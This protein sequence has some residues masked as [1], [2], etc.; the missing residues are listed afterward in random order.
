LLGAAHAVQHV[1]HFLA[2]RGRRSRLAV[3]AGEHGQICQRDGEFFQPGFQLQDCRQH[4]FASRGFQHQRMRQVVD[5]FRGAGEV[6]EFAHPHHFRVAGQLVLQEVFDRLD[7][8]IG[9]FLM[10]LHRL[11]VGH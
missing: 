6:D 8:V 9:G 7:V 1:G 2:Q 11:R 4:D 5:V 10:R 3:R